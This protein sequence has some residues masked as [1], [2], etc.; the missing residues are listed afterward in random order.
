M[1]F[2]KWGHSAPM[3]ERALLDGTN[4]TVLVDRKIVYPYDIAIDFPLQHIYWVDS[5]LDFVER[6][7]YDGTN[8]RTVKRG[9]PVS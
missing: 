8:R 6:I 7:N 2:T 3:L 1:F 4:R 5:Y 9:Y